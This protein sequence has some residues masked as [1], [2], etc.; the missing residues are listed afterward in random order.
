MERLQV[1]PQQPAVRVSP[2]SR[3]RLRV[4]YVFAGHRRR[5]D[6]RAHLEAL[7]EKH[8]FELDMH[9]VDLV[10]GEDQDVLDES[11]WCELLRF[12]R[13]FRPFCIIATPPCST[14]S[15]ARHLYKRIPGPRPIR[16]RE[17]PDGF[18]WLNAKKLQ[19]AAQGTAFADKTWE[20]A[21]LAYELDA[22]FLSEFPEDLGKTDTGVPASLW[23]MQKFS[24]CLA[25]KNMK[26]FALFQC[27]FGAQ[28]PK[29]T[30][31][32]SDLDHFIGNFYLGAPEFYDDWSYK[33]PLP[34][35]CPHPGAHQPLIGTDHEGKWKTGPAAHYPGPLCNFLATAIYLSW[36][37]SSSASGGDLLQ[38]HRRG[39]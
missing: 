16:S 14:Y 36:A 2:V 39:N 31:F 15:R 28:T 1:D 9:E 5:A 11:F 8:G 30:R 32:L 20:L 34:R 21:D 4:A 22:A 23:Q 6:V 35:V 19:Q 37:D 10:R 38:S 27:E 18:P 3:P 12:L 33:G 26:T 7:A 25:R 24:D 29:P 17:H 13:D